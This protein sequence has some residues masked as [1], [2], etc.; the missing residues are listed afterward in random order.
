MDLDISKLN[1]IE[2]RPYKISEF[3]SLISYGPVFQTLVETKCD[4][5]KYNII[6][7]FNI[8]SL[9][10]VGFKD[11]LY[12]FE[13]DIRTTDDL[14]TN[15]RV[16]PSYKIKMDFNNNSIDIDKHSKIYLCLFRNKIKIIVFFNREVENF[17]ITYTAYMFNYSIRQKLIQNNERSFSNCL[18]PP[19][20]YYNLDF[21]CNG[22]PIIG[23]Y[24]SIYFNT[25][26]KLK[27]K[28]T[29]DD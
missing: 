7:E 29:I 24:S 19:K 11:N 14:I 1:I 2:I 20:L 16:K 22:F 6:D 13:Y 12:F 3:K 27:I 15:I 8:N 17:K 10:A 9:P 4:A 26:D 21:N 23:D 5:V 18:E 28:E 25:V